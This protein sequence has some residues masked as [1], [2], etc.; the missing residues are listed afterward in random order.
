[1][2]A[3]PEGSLETSSYPS[4]PLV[5]PAVHGGCAEMDTVVPL[6]QRLAKHIEQLVA[7]PDDFARKRSESTKSSVIAAAA[8][9]SAS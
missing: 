6:V 9:M 1:V 2:A 7:L 4:A 3:G 5:L 8:T